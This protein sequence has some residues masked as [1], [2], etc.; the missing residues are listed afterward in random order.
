[1]VVNTAVS[2]AGGVWPS[3][4]LFSSPLSKNGRPDFAAADLE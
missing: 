2:F 1:M 3:S 4:S